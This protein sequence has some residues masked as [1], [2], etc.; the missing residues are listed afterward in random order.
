MI[1]KETQ[2]ILWWSAVAL[3]VALIYSTLGVAPRWWEFIDKALGGHGMGVLYVLYA[4]IAASVFLYLVFLKKETSPAKYF[5]FFLGVVLTG[6]ILKSM[7]YPAE[8][9]H[10]AEYGLLGVACYHALK[11]D[12]DRLQWK[13]Y[14]VG[15][16]FCI[17]VGAIDEVIQL[18]LP[19]RYFDWR[20]LVVNGASGAIV[21]CLT[22][23]SIIKEAR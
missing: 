23:L 6:A 20:D 17:A 3:Y 12:M 2:R 10:F 14:A 13:L 4:G 11:I 22:R 5:W 8:K 9:I 18:I 7:Y 19:N 21:L 1:P 16:L 15:S